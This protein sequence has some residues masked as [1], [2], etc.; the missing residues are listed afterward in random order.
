MRFFKSKQ[1]LNTNCVIHV[2]CSMRCTREMCSMCERFSLKCSIA[3]ENVDRMRTFLRISFKQYVH[4][5]M[6]ETIFYRTNK[7]SKH[8]FST[9]KIF[10]QCEWRTWVRSEN[11]HQLCVLCLNPSP[12]LRRYVI[13]MCKLFISACVHTENGKSIEQFCRLSLFW[14]NDKY[15]H[16]R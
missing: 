1:R 14:K 6:N 4:H 9:T 13:W 5:F 3:C 15:C 2:C 16:S 8:S 7:C 10:I 11:R 12:C